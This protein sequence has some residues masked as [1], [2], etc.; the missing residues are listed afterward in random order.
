M[1]VALHS[2]TSK[3]VQYVAGVATLVFCALVVAAA[4][5]LTASAGPRSR[6]RSARLMSA[7]GSRAG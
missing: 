7:A 4:T 6:W 2:D 3:L 1:Y 5:L